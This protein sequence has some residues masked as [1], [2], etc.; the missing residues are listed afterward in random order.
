MSVSTGTD[1]GMSFRDFNEAFKYVYQ[2][3][4]KERLILVIDEIPYLVN[5][6]HGISSLLAAFID[7]KYLNTKLY[8]ILC[9]SSLSFMEHQVLGYQ[10]P[11]YGRRTAQMKIKP[12]TFAES[13][14]YYRKFNKQDL[15]VAYGIT[16]GILLYMSKIDDKKTIEDNIKDNFFDPSAYLFEE[17]GNLIKQECHEPMQYNAI[18][19]AIAIFFGNDT[20]RNQSIDIV[21]CGTGII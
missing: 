19:R 3:A 13:S 6:Y 5:C 18:I 16:G 14:R 15:A 10:S 11:L 2:M 7:H 8:L 20:N 21:T 4:Q 12:F 9:V 1:V 17:P